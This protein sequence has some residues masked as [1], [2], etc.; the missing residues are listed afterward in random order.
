MKKLCEKAMVGLILIVGATLCMY[1]FANI[2]TKPITDIFRGKVTQAEIE[3]GYYMNFVG[4]IG[5]DDV[6]ILTSKDVTLGSDDT[7][8]SD[9]IV[10]YD[11]D[12]DDG[13]YDAFVVE[14]ENII[15]LNYYELR[16]SDW[17]NMARRS[18][19]GRTIGTIEIPLKTEN[20][21]FFYDFLYAGYYLVELDDGSYVTAFM[22][23][24]YANSKTLPIAVPELTNKDWKE[25]LEIFARDNGDINIEDIHTDYI[26]IVQTDDS[27][28]GADWID[29]ISRIASTFILAVV[30]LVGFLKLN[31]KLK[32]MK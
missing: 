26:L 7:E 24:D 20:P 19:R 6:P 9:S 25:H 18:S 30:L 28:Y 8:K 27:N 23:Q 16:N 13:D 4:K 17:Q 10:G 12:T 14:T 11:Y 5:A 1:F 15:P 2:P 21:L 32:L 3:N 31:K 29:L 22:N